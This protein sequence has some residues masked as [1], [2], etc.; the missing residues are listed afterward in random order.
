SKKPAMVQASDDFYPR[1][2]V[3]QII[4]TTSVACNSVFLGEFMQ[5]DWTCFTLFIQRQSTMNQPK[6][7]AMDQ[8]MS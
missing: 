2:P 5:P 4:H 6:P 1:Y 8:F 7:L 3:L